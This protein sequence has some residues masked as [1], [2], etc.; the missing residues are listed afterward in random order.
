M[1][2]TL[3]RGF[4]TTSVHTDRELTNREGASKWR[5]KKVAVREGGRENA[6]GSCYRRWVHTVCNQNKRCFPP[7]ERRLEGFEESPESLFRGKKQPKNLDS[8]VRPSHNE[9][10]AWTLE[11]VGVQCFSSAFQG[12]QGGRG[13]KR[14]S[15]VFNWQTTLPHRA[16]QREFTV[17]YVRNGPI[18]KTLFH[19][20]SLLYTGLD[21]QFISNS[22]LKRMQSNN[23]VLQ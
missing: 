13:S 8:F 15:F 14:A 5:K 3:G 7:R 20:T 23:T 12:I 1:S 9:I 10:Q 21:W 17:G 11:R 19:T 2:S 18:N 6:G 16:R 22:Q 4:Y